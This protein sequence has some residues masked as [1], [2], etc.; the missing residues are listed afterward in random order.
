MVHLSK[1]VKKYLRLKA[2]I[3]FVV[4]FLIFALIFLAMLYLSFYPVIV[5]T[6]LGILLLIQ[7]ILFVLL[8][9]YIY[10]KVTQYQVHENRIVTVEGFIF[11]HHK[12]LPLKRVQGVK[13]KHGIISRR[14]N[15]AKLSVTTAGTTFHL[16]PVKIK[17]ALRVQKEMI[18]LVKGE[19]IDV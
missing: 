12:M 16:P 8:K 11:V 15:L 4:T 13:I 7:F 2:T 10:Q 5:S 14:Y 17:E 3:L 6:A 1:E 19:F 9:P 18:N